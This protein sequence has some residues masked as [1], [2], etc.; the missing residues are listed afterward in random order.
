MNWQ[1]QPDGSYIPAD[2]GLRHTYIIRRDRE[3]Q[4]YRPEADGR[5][6]NR[7]PGHNAFF[8]LREAKQAC[9]KLEAAE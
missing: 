3:A 2:T 9:E 7:K 8:T 1:K 4:M 5:P 6:V